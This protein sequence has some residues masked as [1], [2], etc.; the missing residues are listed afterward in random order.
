MMKWLIEHWEFVLTMVLLVINA[1]LSQWEDVYKLN[2]PKKRTRQLKTKVGFAGFSLVAAACLF[3]KADVSSERQRKELSEKLDAANDS[4]T[5]L[6]NQLAASDARQWEALKSAS[7]KDIKLASVTAELAGAKLNAAKEKGARLFQELNIDKFDLSK[8]RD[9]LSNRRER[10]RL[11]EEKKRLDD[12]LAAPTIKAAE[13]KARQEQQETAL[14][15]KEANIDQYVPYVEDTLTSLRSMLRDALEGTAVTNLNW[16]C[17]DV[18]ELIANNDRCQ[19]K[20]GDKSPWLYHA[21]INMLKP[22]M[23]RM[24]RLQIICM[25]STNNTVSYRNTLDVAWLPH[26]NR[27]RIDFS[28][29]RGDVKYSEAGS[30][31]ES[32]NLVRA[33]LRDLIA[34]HP[35]IR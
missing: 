16:N 22:G 9:A 26:D 25:Q 28:A 24:M 32:T 15:Q 31:L 7:E 18:R 2:D 20:A 8:A 19:I 33:S 10:M 1:L 14:K 23:G 30:L 6:T 34:A 27:V 5:N 4:I 13:E 3:W 11:E 29:F 12:A 17:Q 21:I 35:D